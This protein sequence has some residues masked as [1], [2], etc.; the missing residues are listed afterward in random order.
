MPWLVTPESAATWIEQLANI[1]ELLANRG[2]ATYID[3]PAPDMAYVKLP[4]DP[5]VT[6][7]A[8][9]A[10][11]LTGAVILSLQRRPELDQLIDLGG[12]RVHAVGMP[13]AHENMPPA[14]T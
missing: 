6:I 14:V 2:M 13:E 12:W 9:A 3:Y 5:A 4:P 8:A 11:P 7:R 10:V 1:T